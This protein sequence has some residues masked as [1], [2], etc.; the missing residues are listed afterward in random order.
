MTML[1]QVQ[2]VT[3]SSEANKP[4]G[5]VLAYVRWRAMTD[6][7]SGAVKAAPKPVCV[8]LP[9]LSLIVTSAEVLAGSEAAKNN[10]LQSAVSQFVHSLRED[11]IKG[12]I[13]AQISGNTGMNICEIMIP[14]ELVTAEGLAAYNAEANS[15]ARLKKEDLDAWFDTSMKDNLQAAVLAKFGEDKATPALLDKVASDFKLAVGRMAGRKDFG[16]IED[17]GKLHKTVTEHGEDGK[18]KALLLAKLTSAMNPPK[19]GEGLID[20]FG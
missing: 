20:L 7:A 14:A 17:L 11:V 12:Y 6:K 3:A 16:S 13:E 8:A 18:V 15:G 4:T 5:S 10:P 1:Y 9:A 19:A 2:S